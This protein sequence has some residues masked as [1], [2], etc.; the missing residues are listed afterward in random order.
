MFNSEFNWN[1]DPRVDIKCNKKL[2]LTSN[3]RMVLIL[4]TLLTANKKVNE[5]ENFCSNFNYVN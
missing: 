3:R 5:R 1:N 2:L 4:M